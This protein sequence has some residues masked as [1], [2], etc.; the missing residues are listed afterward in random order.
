MAVGGDILFMAFFYGMKF[1]QQIGIELA[2]FVDRINVQKGL[3]FSKLH[4]GKSYHKHR[5]IKSNKKF[6]RS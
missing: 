3:Q 6:I 4:L 1:C 2:L 5:V